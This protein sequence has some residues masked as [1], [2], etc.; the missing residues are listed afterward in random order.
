[1]I[2]IEEFQAE[3]LNYATQNRLWV[4]IQLSGDYTELDNFLSGIVESEGRLLD[5][6]GLPCT[7]SRS[8]ILQKHSLIIGLSLAD[9]W[10]LYSWLKEEANQYFLS[11]T[12]S[13][14]QLLSDAQ[15]EKVYIDEV[16]P[17]TSLGI[18]AE[19]YYLYLYYE[20]L[21]KDKIGPQLFV[22]EVRKV[23]ENHLSQRLHSLLVLEGAARNKEHQ[24]LAGYGLKHLDE[25]LEGYPIFEAEFYK[26]TIIHD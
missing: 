11:A 12:V 13:D 9:V 5:K 22:E 8:E 6:F 19:S 1:M 3:F 17:Q 24:I 16:L 2:T 4:D 26:S 23:K 15:K 21:L 10:S 20:L 18:R 7:L 25:F 14:I